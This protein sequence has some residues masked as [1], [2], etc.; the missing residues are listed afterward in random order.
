MKD[1]EAQVKVQTQLTEPFKIRQGLK[2]GDRLV[3]SLFNLVLDYVIRKLSVSIKGTVEH[4]TAQIIG[5][6]DDICLLSRNVRRT[7]EVHQELKEAAIEIGFHI[8]TSK[9]KVMIMS[10]SKVNA[11][12]C[13]NVG[14]HSIELVNS[15]VYLGSCIT[16]DNNELSEIQRRLI[17]ANN[18][19][20][21]LLAVIKSRMVCKFVK[22]RL[23]KT[24]IR[25]VLPYG[26][27]SWKLSKKTRP[28]ELL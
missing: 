17:L 2:Q 19:Y 1:S 8:N 3:P 13:L 28:S 4:H 15:F 9:I 12:Q 5:Y 22:V 25:T 14:G 16:D 7:E 24:L 10:C 18:A 26:C 6:A 21:S 11:D 23:Y 27:E 20:Y